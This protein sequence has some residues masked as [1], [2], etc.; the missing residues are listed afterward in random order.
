MLT[1]STTSLINQCMSNF[2]SSLLVSLTYSTRF[3][4]QSFHWFLTVLPG[5]MIA[6][7]LYTVRPGISIFANRLADPVSSWLR[8]LLL[9]CGDLCPKAFWKGG[10]EVQLYYE[11]ESEHIL[12]YENHN[13][14]SLCFVGYPFLSIHPL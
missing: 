11:D 6:H 4:F 3:D 13:E 12:T 8:G 14:S 9:P 7:Y 2:R 10:C 1:T 5:S